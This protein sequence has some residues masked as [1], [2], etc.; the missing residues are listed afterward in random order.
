[1]LIAGLSNCL[2]IGLSFKY[3][4]ELFQFNESS[5]P[6]SFKQLHEEEKANDIE[7][8]I[9]KTEKKLS[10]ND[11][12]SIITKV[13]SNSQ[14]NKTNDDLS[15]DYPVM[16][17]IADRIEK[18]KNVN[19][20]TKSE[21]NV[22]IAVIILN[23]ITNSIINTLLYIVLIS[24]ESTFGFNVSFTFLVVSVLA[25]KIIIKLTSYKMFNYIEDYF[26]LKYPNSR[27]RANA[28]R[29]QTKLFFLICLSMVFTYI[30]PFTNMFDT[31][32]IKYICAILFSFS[33][34]CRA[35]IQKLRTFCLKLF[36]E[37]LYTKSEVIEIN[38]TYKNYF[39]FFKFLF[40][41]LTILFFNFVWFSR[42]NNRYKLFDFSLFSSALSMIIMIVIRNK[43]DLNR[44]VI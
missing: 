3:N 30:I 22:C 31:P 24:S 13:S 20:I 17:T 38:Q 7:K 40:R 29:I 12:I 18:F 39:I 34:F 23:E 2:A 10:S 25:I 41:G 42:M 5:D 21:R 44:I 16:T 27:R 8:T 15:S 26:Y 19:P 36:M 32:K 14:Y 1:M 35:V 37:S 33:L 43:I 11:R 4:K 9:E 6:I 28:D